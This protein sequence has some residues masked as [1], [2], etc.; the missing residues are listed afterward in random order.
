MSTEVTE[1]K[2]PLAIR[3][4]VVLILVAAPVILYVRATDDEPAG[5]R[6]D[7]TS[8]SASPVASPSPASASPT[9]VARSTRPSTTATPLQGDDG[10]EATIVV[11]A[12]DQAATRSL[13]DAVARVAVGGTITL[14]PGRYALRETL[15]IDDALRLAGSGAGAVIV[16]GNLTGDLVRVAAD[17]RCSLEGITFR[18]EGA[19]AGDVIDVRS[20]DLEVAG[21]VIQGGSSGGVAGRGCGVTMA[22]DGELVMRRCRVRRNEGDG[23]RIGASGSLDVRSCTSS[24][25]AAGLRIRGA[26]A[27]AR[28]NVF[29]SNDIGVAVVGSTT[30]TISA[31]RCR[32][33]DVGI[34]LEDD[35]TNVRSNTCERNR[36]DAIRAVG[37]RAIIYDNTCRDNGAGITAVATEAGFSGFDVGGNTVYSSERWGICF[38]RGARGGVYRNTCHGNAVGLRVDP[39][40][41][42]KTEANDF[43]GNATAVLGSV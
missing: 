27:I 15:V 1:A 18:R 9:G 35:S 6:G 16:T 13:A 39:G 30:A 12:D 42:V 8:S 23:V 34:L 26:W 33:N 20:G 43:S 29:S 36:R 19:G 31:N 4:L 28:D 3:I 11:G 37:S 5:G 7:R 14:E 41:R 25:N 40:C 17:G 10:G 22:G 24:G 2:A 38:T 21:C 32:E